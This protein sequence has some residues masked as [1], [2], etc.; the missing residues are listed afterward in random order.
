M[1]RIYFFTGTGNSLHIAKKIAE[2]LGDCEVIAIKKGADKKI[3]TGYD[4]IGF[5]FPTYG[6]GAPL[7]VAKFLRLAEFPEQGGTYFFTVATCGGLVLNAIPQVKMLLRK[8]GIKLNYGNK[9][10]MYRNSVANYKM[11]QDPQKLMIKSDESAV[12][13]IDDIKNKRGNKIS[14]MNRLIYKLNKEFMKS[15]PAMAKDFVVSDD[16]VSCGICKS[17]CPA[18]NIE[19][20]DGKPMF[21]SHCEGCVACIQHCPKQAINYKDKTQK[22]G[23]Y[24]HPAIKSREIAQYY[25]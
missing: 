20:Q 23:R 6:W 8:K 4:R 5:V 3:P 11:G 12:P 19:L 14:K 10:A 13:V 21:G 16:C 9:V 25:K 15:M 18:E 22:R 24:V 1:N 17:V 2:E 7:M